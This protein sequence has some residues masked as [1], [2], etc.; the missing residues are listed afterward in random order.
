MFIFVQPFSV[1][2]YGCIPEEFVQRVPI[3]Q[4]HEF[5]IWGYVPERPQNS[6]KL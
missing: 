3:Y 4:K 2:T 5:S 6:Q 1:F